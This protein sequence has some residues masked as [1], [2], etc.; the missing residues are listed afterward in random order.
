MKKF[1]IALLLTAC[2]P[3]SA[4]NY[5]PVENY[6]FTAIARGGYDFVNKTPNINVGIGF[7]IGIFKAE[8]EIGGTQ[9]ILPDLSEYKM[10]YAATMCGFTFGTKH[11][12]YAM[13][14]IT[15]WALVEL[16]SDDHT[17]YTL[18]DGFRGKAKIGANFSLTERLIF[19]VDLSGICPYFRRQPNQR[20]YVDY[21]NV[22]LSAGLGFKI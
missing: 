19:N 13:I 2:L 11:S 20:C 9:F 8:L 4:L 14:G 5:W 10:P 7:S 15:N 1:I 6:S 12:V 18:C 16:N 22:F 21:T 3:L 17:K